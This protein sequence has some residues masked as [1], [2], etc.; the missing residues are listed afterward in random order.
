MAKN[1]RLTPALLRKLVLQEKKKIQESLEKGEESV[2][3]VH[4][5]EVDAGD[6]A[7]SLEKDIDWMAALK[8]QE[9]ILK[10]KYAKVQKAKKRLVKK[11]TNR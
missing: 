5:E 10:K 3:D 8:I 2:E 7:D 6:E 11:I 1:I 4:A 9:S